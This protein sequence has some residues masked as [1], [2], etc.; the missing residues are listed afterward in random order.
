M[1]IQINNNLMKILLISHNFPPMETPEAIRSGKYAKYLNRFGVNMFVVH[2]TGE[3]KNSLFRKGL[4][5]FDIIPDPYSNWVK[6]ATNEALEIIEK[7][8]IE[9]II[10]RS[11]PIAS[12]FV[13]LKV[14]E[15]HPGLPWIAEFSD[16]WTQNTY[17]KYPILGWG[18][19]RDNKNEQKIFKTANKVIATSYRTAQLFVDKYPWA[20]NKIEAIPNFYDEEDYH[21]FQKRV[22]NRFIILHTG[23]FYGIRTPEPFLKALLE[24]HTENPNFTDTILVAFVGSFGKYSKVL[25]KY[26]DQLPPSLLKVKPPIERNR[27]GN[28]LNYADAFLLIDAPLN[29]KNEPS[30]FLPS[31]LPEYLYM[32]KPILALTPSGTSRD[33]I[34]QTGAGIFV[35]PDNVASIKE[36]LKLIVTFKM[37]DNIGNVLDSYNAI[38]NIWEL[39]L[40]IKK[41]LLIREEEG[42]LKNETETEPTN[43][44]IQDY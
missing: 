5:H 32:Q 38:T 43:Q 42:E 19:R 26:Q 30:V 8:K 39:F 22:T 35:N 18:S 11:M 41:E 33:I 40:L 1:K 9:L 2:A 17:K 29:K 25:E 3:E 13:A 24:L 23:N 7:E 36:A 4:A 27:I 21:K 6:V 34:I 28:L 44:K 15:K 12:H 16:P 10:S 31:K 14:K 20:I 37:P